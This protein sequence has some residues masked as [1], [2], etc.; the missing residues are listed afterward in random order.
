MKTDA[1]GWKVPED[2]DI[3]IRF[4]IKPKR[5]SLEYYNG[6]DTKSRLNPTY[7][8]IDQIIENTLTEDSTFRLCKACGHETRYSIPISTSLTNN[9]EQLP[10]HPKCYEPYVQAINY[11]KNNHPEK[12]LSKNI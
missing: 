11:L 9:S 5:I 8:A 7:D 6:D 12:L 1:I 3:I 2:T 10:I 4:C